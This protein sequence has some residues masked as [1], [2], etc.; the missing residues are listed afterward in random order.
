MSIYE[1]APLSVSDAAHNL[2]F[3]HAYSVLNDTLQ[4]LAS[5]G[6]FTCKSI[7]LG[8]LLAESEKVLPWNDFAL[9]KSGVDRR[10]DL[11]HRGDVLPRGDC[12]KY[13][14]AIKTE[15]MLWGILIAS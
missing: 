15:L 5:E 1:I 12:W 3:L 8:K 9:I 11:A 7:F 2:P 10:N 6:K 13:I 4:Q 14:D